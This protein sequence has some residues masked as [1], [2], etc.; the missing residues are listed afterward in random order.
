M[1][2]SKYRGGDIADQMGASKCRESFTDT[3]LNGYANSKYGSG[4]PSLII[5]K[6]LQGT[7]A[8]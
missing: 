6:L 8:I 7:Y 5:S 4:G 3:T 1:D 2:V